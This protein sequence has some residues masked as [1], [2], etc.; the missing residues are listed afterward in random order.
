[1]SF[2]KKSKYVFRVYRLAPEIQV[3]C[4]LPQPPSIPWSDWTWR[5]PRIHIGE[6]ALLSWAHG[7]VSFPFPHVGEG[8][9]WNL[10]SGRPQA[11]FSL[12]VH[13]KVFMLLV[14]A[15]LFPSI[16][17][18]YL[19]FPSFLFH[20]TRAHSRSHRHHF[21]LLCCDFSLPCS[22]H[23]LSLCLCL[24]CLILW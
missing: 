2:K 16:P 23:S 12:V 9:T 14:F 18:P 10:E 11:S 22:C 6:Y 24:L 19:S 8:S 7:G 4:H 5:R 3:D 17:V 20:C 21:L 15:F 1:M 13:K